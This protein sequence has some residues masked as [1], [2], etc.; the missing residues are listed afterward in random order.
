M[1]PIHFLWIVGIAIC[2][3]VPQ[4]AYA[5]PVPSAGSEESRFRKE[6]EFQENTEKL[7][8]ATKEL[9]EP[10]KP[11]EET[12][13]PVS[14]EEGRPI[15]VK[16]VRFL[17]N[18]SVSESELRP[19]VEPLIGHEVTLAQIRD[20]ASEIRKYY[21]SLGF[22]AAYV[23]VPSQQMTDGVLKLDILEGRISEVKIS[24]NHYFST[25]LL[26]KYAHLLKPGEV[27]KYD[28]LWRTV[29]RL[30]QRRDIQAK[31]VL[32]PGASTGTTAIDISVK[33]Q[34][35]IHWS[36]DVSN[37]G[38]RNTGK[39]R[40]G[41]SGEHN[42]LTGHAD[43]LSGTALLGQGADALG[44][45]YSIPLNIES[46]TRFGYGVSHVTTKIGGDFR[47][48][49]VRGAATTHNFSL[50]QPLL[51]KE[52]FLIDG[53]VGY[54]IKSIRNKLLGQSSGKDELRIL[55]GTLSFDATDADGRTLSSHGVYQGLSGI[56]G[57]SD[58]VDDE[59]SR[60]G[61][62]GRFFIYRGSIMRFQKLPHELLLSLRGE[63]Q[64]TS[65]AV[66]ASEQFSLGGARTVRGYQDGEYLADLGALGAADL[67]IPVFFFPEDWKLPGANESLRKQVQ[68][69]GF[70][71]IGGGE[72]KKFLPGELPDKF[73]AGAGAGVRV[74]LYDN[75][76]G[77]FEWA[78]PLGDEPFDHRK[79]AYY[80]TVAY[81]I[82]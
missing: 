22:V 34:F 79:S 28:D 3:A 51:E 55:S 39:Y 19:M 11:S 26:E 45:A 15:L 70:A 35:P 31:A 44:G 76:Y 1:R 58:P 60:I 40:W 37:S 14:A 61:T 80:F 25:P 52:G 62:G 53:K 32:E 48:L 18:R 56:M 63:W 13:A 8:T 33:D 72:L 16:E 17:G 57:G 50:L 74:H 6:K 24:D 9:V 68:M 71:D 64:A 54:D 42:N 21:R 10:A 73:L 69:V 7:M 75:M 78:F 38:A 41:L 5:D 4:D 49:D 81:E 77:R 43:E 65:Y 12:Q 29:N 20:A 36:T 46:G 67:F 82:A 59:A 47:P 30:N 66:P 27:L 23:Y 2:C